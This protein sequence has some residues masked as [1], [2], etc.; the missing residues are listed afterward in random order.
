MQYDLARD[1][2]GFGQAQG[3]G[4]PDERESGGDPGRDLPASGTSTTSAASTST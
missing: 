2:A 4:G 1:R 3:L